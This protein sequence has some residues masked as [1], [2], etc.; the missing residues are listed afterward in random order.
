M[1][2]FQAARFAPLACLLATS[3]PAAAQTPLQSLC[4]MGSAVE[5]QVGSSWWEG[6]VVAYDRNDDLCGVKNTSYSGRPMVF[7]M[8]ADRIRR[9]GAAPGEQVGATPAHPLCVPGA[10]LEVK[11]GAGW[12]PG[13]VRE[14]HRTDG[15]CLIANTTYVGKEFLVYAEPD[16]MRLPSQANPAPAPQPASPAPAP[17][18]AP[19]P[20]PSAPE[21]AAPS[22]PPPY[23][24][25]LQAA[26][27]PPAG[28]YVCRQY[29]TTMG[30][31]TLDGKGGYEISGVRGQYRY[32]PAS[33]EFEWL[34][35]SYKDWKWSAR[36]E[37]RSPESLGRPDDEHI[38]RTTD[39]TG[40]LK[41]DCFLMRG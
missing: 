6:E 23:G 36:Y 25:A 39:D 30:Y 14:P 20:A 19:A 1:R 27:S 2:P 34:S 35:G 40:K 24:P 15:S 13:V 17:V 11:I 32:S 37:Y 22:S 41:I 18:P 9:A 28:R 31:L 10:K 3:L 12:F 16:G 29:M 8:A 33:G 5:I 26:G 21:P 4:V 7:A 38:I